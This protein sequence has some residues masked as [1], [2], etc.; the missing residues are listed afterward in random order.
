MNQSERR[1]YLIKRLLE[2]RSDC[3]GMQIPSGSE[4]Q[5]RLLRSLMNI[6]MPGAIDADFLKIQDK[7]LTQVNFEKGIVKLE[8][9]QE[10]QDGSTYV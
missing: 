10:I 5:R 2:E 9:I 4:A 1:I 7:Y 6:R 8:D 3:A